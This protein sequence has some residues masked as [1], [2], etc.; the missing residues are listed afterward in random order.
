MSSE[1]ARPSRFPAG[2]LA[3]R[4]SL[5]LSLSL[6]PARKGAPLVGWGG[7]Q[8]IH[9]RAH[10]DQQKRQFPFSLLLCLTSATSVCSVVKVW[11]PWSIC[12]SPLHRFARGSSGSPLPLG[13]G[14]GVGAT[15]GAG[16]R[17]AHGARGR[18]APG[19]CPADRTRRSPA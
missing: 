16:E 18:C 1:Q 13:E 9:H 11:D 10:S 14:L 8:R 19:R 4:A 15:T 12:R 3:T 6:S 17:A 5:S 7:G 2:L